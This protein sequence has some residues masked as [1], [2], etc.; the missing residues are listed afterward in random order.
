MND[1]STPVGLTRR[2]FIKRSVVAAVAVSS[3]TIF[4]GLVNAN[5]PGK[6]YGVKF[7]PPIIPCTMTKLANCQHVPE[8]DANGNVIRVISLCDI[9]CSNSGA[10]QKHGVTCDENDDPIGFEVNN[11][12]CE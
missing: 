12:R 8:R 11:F 6:G 9:K 4:S 5:L 3:M 7:E 10:P 1:T 2:S